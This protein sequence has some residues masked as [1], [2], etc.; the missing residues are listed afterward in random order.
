M[1]SLRDDI[2]VVQVLIFLM[3]QDCEHLAL[4]FCFVGPQ[5]HCLELHLIQF[6]RVRNLQLLKRIVP[7]ILV[8]FKFELLY[9]SEVGD[10][11][12]MLSE[13]EC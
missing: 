11:G 3:V 4:D 9:R 5:I 7:V 8:S 6:N 12:W 10:I 2:V 13:P 1:S